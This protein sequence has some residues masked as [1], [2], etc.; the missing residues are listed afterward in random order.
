MFRTC[1]LG[2]LGGAVITTAAACGSNSTAPTV[3]PAS[4]TETWSS[5]LTVGASKFYSFTVPLEGTVSVVMKTFTQNGA[6]STEQVTIG[7]GSPHGTDCSVAG[8]VVASASDSVLLSGSQTRGVYC[9]RI[10]DN[11][12]L[13]KTA[14][15]SVNITHPKQ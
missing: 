7:L 13:S 1:L 9:I 14:A 8:S 5:T 15:F 2:L 3:E 4:T 11:A 12:Q 6:A 10:W